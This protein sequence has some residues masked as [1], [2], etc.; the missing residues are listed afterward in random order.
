[1]VPSVPS[2]ILNTHPDGGNRSS[3]L[4]VQSQLIQKNRPCRELRQGL[5]RNALSGAEGDQIRTLSRL[6]LDRGASLRLRT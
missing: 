6:R 5:L 3:S 1:M 2:R 4:R